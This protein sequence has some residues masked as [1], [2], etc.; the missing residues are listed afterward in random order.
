VSGTG[1]DYPEEP[2][3]V[4]YVVM[5]YSTTSAPGHGRLQ[6]VHDSSQGAK[7]RIAW[8]RRNRPDNQHHYYVRHAEHLN[9]AGMW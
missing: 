1:S 4:V 9:S 7:D 5:S 3:T 6:G 2:F 8:I